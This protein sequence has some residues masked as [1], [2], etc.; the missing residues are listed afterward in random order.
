VGQE[1]VRPKSIAREVFETCATFNDYVRE[2]GL[3]R[4]EGVL[5]RYL[6]ESYKT[7]LTNV[8]EAA[9]DEGVEDIL[10]FLLTTLKQV[11]SSLLE[12]WQQL[13]AGPLPKD[14]AAPQPS[15]PP[16]DL[17][18]DLK[19]LNAR[20]R[21]EA[22]RLVFAL[23][24]KNYEEAATLLP[25]ESGWTAERL[26]QEMEPYWQVHPTIDTTP[27][28]RAAHLTFV[29]PDGEPRVF[30]IRHNLLSP[31]GEADFA[32]EGQVDLRNR[33]DADE[34]LFDLRSIRS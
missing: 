20:I 12:E 25:V 27:R 21:A 31:D 7:F 2:Y 5:L 23:A 8:P 6:S 19:K 26:E 4:S 13:S 9:R 11:D 22:H 15:K 16:V 17:A 3:Q 29:E 30:R 24:R 1:D 10:A 33:S 28:A 18:T 34:A 32:L 14:Q